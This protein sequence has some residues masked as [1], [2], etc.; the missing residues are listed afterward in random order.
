MLWR[1]GNVA[2][3]D[4]DNDNDEARSL[5]AIE[6]RTCDV[7]VVVVVVV[8]SSDWHDWRLD[9]KPREG[10]A[11]LLSCGAVTF[12]GF[13]SFCIVDAFAAYER[14][15]DCARRQQQQSQ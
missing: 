3:D 13:A 10:G 4:G 12:I 11:S 14:R 6:S 15:R 8:V 7:V 5:L 9:I 2:S 1:V